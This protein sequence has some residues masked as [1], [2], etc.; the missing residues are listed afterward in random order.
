MTKFK[1]LFFVSLFTI[2]AISITK[3]QDKKT[4]NEINQKGINKINSG[5]PNRISMNVTVPKQT[6]GATFGEKVNSRLNIT[7]IENGCIV[8]F[9]S[10]EGYKINLTDNSINNLS[11][12]EGLSF[13]EKINAG[14]HATGS[15]ISQGGS[16]LGGALP[17]GA[18]ISAAVSSVSHLSGGGS[19]AASASYAKSSKT[20]YPIDDSSTDAT[21]ELPDG[22]FEL[23]FVIKQTASTKL[24][25]T[26]K[27]QVKIGFSVENGLLKTKHDT[28]KNSISNIR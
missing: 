22:E 24:K 12:D 23:I 6:Q 4:S 2:C 8:L 20:N 19:G 1:T 21:L 15:A 17:G 27:T 11:K 14:V 16:L 3:A 7:L 28:V 26:L 5:M 9:P 13:G 18:I 25:E 10:N